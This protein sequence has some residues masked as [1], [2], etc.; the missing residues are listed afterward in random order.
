M[1]VLVNLNLIYTS[2]S[3]KLTWRFGSQGF[4]GLTYAN[5]GTDPTRVY[6]NFFAKG[7]SNSQCEID[8]YETVN[9]PKLRRKFAA[10]VSGSW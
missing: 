2:T 7:K 9:G 1:L 10:N 6:L 3:P 8:L 4:G 5:L